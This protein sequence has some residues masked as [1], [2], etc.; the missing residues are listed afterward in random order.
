LK[1]RRFRFDLAVARR[2]RAWIE[3]KKDFGDWRLGVG[4]FCTFNEW[5]D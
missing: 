3:T 1:D 4:D 5:V 2:V